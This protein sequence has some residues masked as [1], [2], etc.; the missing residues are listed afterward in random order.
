[1]TARTKVGQVA[2]VV[3]DAAKATVNA[4][5]D[6]VVQPVGKSLGLIEAVEHQPPTRTETKA[7]RKAAVEVEITA[8]K[9]QMRNQT[10][11]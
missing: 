5:N 11:R 10:G 4:A 7:A 8:R 6:Y 3:A 9:S 1:M 2:T